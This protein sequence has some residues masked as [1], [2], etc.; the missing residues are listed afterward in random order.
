MGIV[1]E[2]KEFALKGNLVDMAVG[3]VIGGAF[4]KIVSSLVGDVIMP[5][6]GSLTGGGSFGSQF[7]WLGEGDKP[8]TIEAAK[9]SGQAFIGWGPFL[10]NTIDFLIIALAIFIVIKAMNTLRLD[11][12]TKRKKSQP[13]QAM[14]SNCWAKSGTHWP[15]GTRSY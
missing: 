14:K 5:L 1:K 2:F 13:N 9:E 4:G 8:A 11:S 10:Q 3:I 7:L 6:V 12:R 15:T